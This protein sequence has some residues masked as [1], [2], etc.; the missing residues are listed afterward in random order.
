MGLPG[1][2]QATHTREVDQ[3]SD[4]GKSADKTIYWSGV[5]DPYA[6]Q[7]RVTQTIWQALRDASATMRPR[8]VVVQTRFRPDRDVGLMKEYCEGTA[9]S[10]QG[11]PVVVSFS[12]GTDRN[13]LIRAWERTTPPY[14]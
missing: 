10:D 2:Q 4:R 5:T 12:L 13:D 6:A 11:P 3:A 8:R 14:V 7:P 9:P 1:T